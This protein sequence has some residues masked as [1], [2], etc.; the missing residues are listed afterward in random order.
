MKVKTTIMATAAAALLTAATIA[1]A[2]AQVQERTTGKTNV[3]T[4]GP[5]LSTGGQVKAQGR[6]GTSN[7]NAQTQ[8]QGGT[9]FSQNQVQSSNL[10]R[11][12]LRRNDFRTSDVNRNRYSAEVYGGKY[13]GRYAGRYRDRDVYA[14]RFRDR[15]R[16]AYGGWGGGDW[17][18]WGPS[19]DVS[20]GYGGWP[21][22]YDYDY[23]YPGLY[24]YSPGYVGVGFGGGGCSCAPGWWR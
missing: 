4:S 3:Q 19:F 24:A 11:S 7:V 6:T 9:N 18:G 2:S 5:N 13:G 10:R 20:V 1:T 15:D 16:F 22:Y 14:G 21:G 17:G 23:G 12:D 8:F